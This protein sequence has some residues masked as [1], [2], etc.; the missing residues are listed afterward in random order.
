MTA[1]KNPNPRDVITLPVRL[2]FPSLF[3]ARTVKGADGSESA[4]KFQATLLLPPDT[5]LKPYAEAI[6]AAMLKKWSQ[7]IVLPSKN[8][9]LKLAD[10]I[11]VYA[12][13]FKGWRVIRAHANENSKPQVIDQRM[14][15]VTDPNRIYSGMWVR[16]YLNAYGWQ[17]PMSGKG[18]SFGLNAIQV[19]RDDDRLDGRKAAQDV[20]TALEMPEAG[21]AGTQAAT[22]DFGGLF[23]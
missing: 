13:Q 12:T 2:S 16:A 11:E 8:N 15:P 6:K 17:H 1:T 7:P 10:E 14:L 3:V 5:D 22:D 18:V 21:D 23:G 19:V 9:P 20:F 4:P